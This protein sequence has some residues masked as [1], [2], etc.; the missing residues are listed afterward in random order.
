MTTVHALTAVADVTM[1]RRSPPSRSRLAPDKKRS[2]PS[3][4]ASCKAD[5]TV[6][7]TAD[8][9]LMPVQIKRAAVLLHRL[10]R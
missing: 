2:H 1:L 7:E 6:D 9:R 8:L 4:S 3:N 5:H 10:T